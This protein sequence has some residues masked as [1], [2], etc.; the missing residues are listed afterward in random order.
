MSKT[1]HWNAVYSQKAEAELSWH[2]DDPSVAIDLM[3]KAGLARHSSVIDIGA[4]TSRLM[5]SLL[6]LGIRD[7]SAL[8][9]SENALSASRHRLG[10]RGQAVKWIVADIT[11][12]EP[13]RTYDIWHD[14]AV[15][16]FLVNPTDQTA[17]I[18]RLARSVSAGGHAIIATFALDGPEKCSG[19]PVARYSPESLAKTL[20]QSFALVLHQEHRHLTPWG[21]PQ[22]FQYSLFRKSN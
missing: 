4:G 7:L 10:A 16:H 1:D 15:F 11:G 17:Y 12:W 21:H 14:R 20:G 2:Q 3:K 5:D 18:E 22:S 9:L 19:F 6:D 13:T 8:D